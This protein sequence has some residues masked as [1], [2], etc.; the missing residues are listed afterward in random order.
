MRQNLTLHKVD[1]TVANKGET[2]TIIYGGNCKRKTADFN[3][4]IISHI[5]KLATTQNLNRKSGIRQT[6]R[7]TLVMIPKN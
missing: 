1:N 6:N 3:K 5:Y 7:A 4:T 2:I